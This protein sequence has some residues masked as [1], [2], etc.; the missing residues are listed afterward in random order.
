MHLPQ[1]LA[2]RLEPLT[3]KQLDSICDLQRSSQQA[4][5]ALSREMEALRQS[6]V[7]T[8]T[9]TGSSSSRRRPAGSSDDCTGEMAAAVA[10]LGALEILL[11]QVNLLCRPWLYC[12]LMCV[13]EF[14]GRVLLNCF[15]A[16]CCSA[17]R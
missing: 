7:E 4:E 10:K 6:I 9:A 8:V 3:E 14:R 1:L 12:K 5:D 15:L 17:G 11:R 2:S 13:S 16:I